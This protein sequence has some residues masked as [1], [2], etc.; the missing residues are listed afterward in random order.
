MTTDAALNR[1]V[2]CA[3]ML[4]LVGDNWVPRLPHDAALRDNAIV[5]LGGVR[6]QRIETWWELRPRAGTPVVVV[7]EVAR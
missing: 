3:A 1:A 4:N 7:Q 5:W 2:E 6:M